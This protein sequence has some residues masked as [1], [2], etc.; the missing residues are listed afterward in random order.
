[1]RPARFK[2]VI[3]L[4]LGIFASLSGCRGRMPIGGRPAPRPMTEEISAVWVARFHYHS[5]D[6]IRTIMKNAAALGFNT[7]LW[8]VRGEGTVA[9]DSRLEPWSAQYKFKNPG[10]DPL[11]VAVAEAHARGL[12]IE[13]WVNVMP[14][15]RG[16]KPPPIRNQLYHQHP[17]WFL[18]DASGK[19]QPLGDF[20][21]ILNPCLPQVRKHIVA[22]MREIVTGY[23]V[24]GLH[25]DYV[26]Y[27]WDT[28]PAARQRYPRDRRTLSIYAHQTGK[29]PD[30]DTKAWDDWRA[31]Q[32]TRLVGEV[33][34]M[35][36]RTRPGVA[37]TA[38]VWSDPNRGYRDY[39]QNAIGWLRG[40]L[41]DAAYPMAYTEDA[42]RFEKYIEAYHALAPG[43]RVVPGLGIYK[44]K[45]AV[46]TASQLAQCR[47]WGGDFAVFSYESLFA[48]AGD[49]GLKPAA[50]AR[51]NRPRELRREEIRRGT[52]S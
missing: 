35:I 48:T 44:H 27:A 38:A 1:M 13:A 12:R 26:R 52:G 47:R 8:Q 33:R 11:A 28:T 34:T 41:I 21:V 42:S 25:M 49:R 40:G 50:L 3:V 39:F 18:R 15:W 32:L 6:D 31:N 22:V 51:K 46:Q 36:D 23:A 29:K 2:P 17:D 5:P 45:L 14:G 9:Y 30:D 24:D 7:V 4:S 43:K 16:P 20:Y 37:L 19:R 10:F